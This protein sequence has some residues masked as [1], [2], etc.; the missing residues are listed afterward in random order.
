MTWKTTAPTDTAPPGIASALGKTCLVIAGGLVLMVVAGVIWNQVRLARDTDKLKALKNE[1]IASFTPPGFQRTNTD[2]KD[3]HTIWYGDN[4]EIDDPRVYLH[5]SYTRPGATDQ[6]ITEAIDAVT[7]EAKRQ[8]FSDEFA[9]NDYPLRKPVGKEWH[10]FTSPSGKIK[11][12]N[13]ILADFKVERIGPDGVL[14]TL[15]Y[16]GSTTETSRR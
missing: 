1:P 10:A 5:I 9:N 13:K 16:N 8:G 14:V 3:D 4:S 11:G 12:Y 2:E 7:A 6:Q 15:D